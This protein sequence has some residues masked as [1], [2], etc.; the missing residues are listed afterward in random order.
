MRGV[1]VSTGIAHGTAF[2]LACVDDTTAPR[3]EIPASEVEVELAR[4]ERALD[5]AE[6]EL[7]ALQQSV[8]ERIGSNEAEI[9]TAQAMLVRDAVF[10]NA[11]TGIVRDKHV[12]VEGAV[13]DAIEHF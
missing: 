7:R 8:S 6:K 5:Q 9:F 12:N 2:V 1:G 3:R 11:V 10:R 13:A 4:F